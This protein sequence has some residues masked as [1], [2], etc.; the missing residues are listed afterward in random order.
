MVLDEYFTLQLSAF[1]ELLVVME[2]AISLLIDASSS[3]E[4]HDFSWILGL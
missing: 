1:D 2:L 4:V 3:S